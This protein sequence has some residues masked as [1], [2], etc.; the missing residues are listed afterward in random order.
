M[1]GGSYGGRIIRRK[2]HMAGEFSHLT[3]TCATLTAFSFKNIYS[4]SKEHINK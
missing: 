1:A 4:T 2:D 3:G